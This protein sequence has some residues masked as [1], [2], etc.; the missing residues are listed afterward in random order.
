[1]SEE[2]FEYMK[3]IQINLYKAPVETKE[4]YHFDLIQSVNSN[5]KF[6]GFYN[7]SVNI[8]FSPAMYI[9]PFRF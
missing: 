4:S 1:M 5:V 3:S 7:G 9:K 6:G 2:K 8:Q